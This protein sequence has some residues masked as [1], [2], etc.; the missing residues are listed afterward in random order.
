ML[1]TFCLTE[2]TSLKSNLAK[3]KKSSRRT[4]ENVLCR[5]KQNLSIAIRKAKG[6]NLF[7]LDQARVDSHAPVG[8]FSVND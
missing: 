8:D 5:R 7:L 2:D 6:S 1:R 4:S 3:E